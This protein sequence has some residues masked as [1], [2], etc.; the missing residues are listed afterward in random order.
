MSFSGGTFTVLGAPPKVPDKIV[1][2]LI[3]F[4]ERSG[5]LQELIASNQAEAEA[6]MQALRERLEDED[7]ALLVCR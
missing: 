7:G 3:K 5:K 1:D 2:D 4:A 6:M